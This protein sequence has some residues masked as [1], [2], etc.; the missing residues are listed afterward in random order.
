MFLTFKKW[1]KIYKLQIIIARVRYTSSGKHNFCHYVMSLSD[2]QNYQQIQQKL[3]SFLKSTQ[4]KK[5]TPN[6]LLFTYQNLKSCK[7]HE[8]TKP[9]S[10]KMLDSLMKN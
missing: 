8:K 1:K 2:C 9:K 4:Y 5:L 3:R 10:I 7:P 6:A